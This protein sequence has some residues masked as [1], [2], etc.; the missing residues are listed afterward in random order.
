MDE[1]PRAKRRIRRGPTPPPPTKR[2]WR[3]LLKAA[4][5]GWERTVG[6]VKAIL[7]ATAV[8]L[9]SITGLA[10]MLINALKLDCTDV[11]LTLS[12]L[13]RCVQR[14]TNSIWAEPPELVE[15]RRTNVG[16]W[17]NWR[18]EQIALAEYPSG[19]D[20]ATLQVSHWGA[21]LES[22]GEGSTVSRVLC[23][24]QFPTDEDAAAYTRAW[25]ERWKPGEAL[26]FSG[27]IAAIQTDSLKLKPCL[28]VSA[29]AD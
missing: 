12:K 26:I 8:I 2:T 9:A 15:L 24:M 17:V 18:G 23:T 3:T 29:S 27:R 20:V 19:I 5:D 25:Q 21:R 22:K 13:D 6:K 4:W 11:D 14:T 28:A 16:R 10:A 1:P 7:S